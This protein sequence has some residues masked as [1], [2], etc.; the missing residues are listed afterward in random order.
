[1]NKKDLIDIVSEKTNN[2]KK[3]TTKIVDSFIEEISKSLANNDKVL[4]S[5]FGTFFVSETKPMN[6]FSPYDGKL[7]KDV[8]QTR[9]RFN[10]SQNLLDKIK[11]AK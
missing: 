11:K 9:V 5:N 2:T 6:I 8:I 10:S 3:N 1:M 4:I 7:I